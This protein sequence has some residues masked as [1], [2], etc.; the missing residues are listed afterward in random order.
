MSTTTTTLDPARVQHVS[1]VHSLLT[2][3]ELAC[4][5]LVFAAVLA[6]LVLSSPEEEATNR[7]SPAALR[8]W[9]A[10]LGAFVRGRARWARSRITTDDPGFVLLERRALGAALRQVVVTRDGTRV[11]D[12]LEIFLHPDDLDALEA[13]GDADAFA[14]DVAGD[15]YDRAKKRAWITDGRPSCRLVKRESVRRGWPDAIGRAV[16][17]TRVR[18]F[19]PTVT[20]SAATALAR[21]S[22]KLEVMVSG[23]DTREVALRPGVM[24]IGRHPQCDV[25]VAEGGVSRHHAVVTVNGRDVTVADAGS[26]N[27]T[28]LD[29]MPVGADDVE[30]PEGALARLGDAV[31]LRW[32][33]AHTGC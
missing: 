22:L 21:E 5:V 27:G 23:R 18:A 20:V 10:A 31:A 16:A 24:E 9:L 25:V 26:T 12:D 11:P 33:K 13:A 7:R 29:G 15:V 1:L 30:W 28:Y 4:A 2:L 6:A 17:G 8:R 14:A 19:E 32:V 3:G